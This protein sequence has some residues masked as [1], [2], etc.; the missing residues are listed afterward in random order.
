MIARLWRGRTVAQRKLLMS[1]VFNGA[2]R[3][4]SL[5]V[6]LI[7]LPI[8]LAGLG[9]D[10]YSGL[11][12]ALAIGASAAFLFGG[13]ASVG[14]RAIGEAASRG[15]HRGEADHFATLL[16][17]TGGTFLLLSALIICYAWWSGQHLALLLVML[18]PIAMSALNASVDSVRVPYNEQYV[19]AAILIGA[20]VLIYGTALLFLPFVARNELTAGLILNGPLIL[21]SLVNA[22]LMLRQRPYLAKGRS[23][24]VIGPAK[25]GG[26]VGLADGALMAPISLAVVW[27]DA[28]GP[29]NLSAWFATVVRLFQMLLTPMLLMLV[30]IAGYVR[31]IWVHSDPAKRR[32]LARASVLAGFG[33]G[34]LSATVLALLISFYVHRVMGLPPP[35]PLVALLPMLA[36]FAAVTTQK[37]YAFVAN[38]VLDAQHL[39]RWTL[40][41]MMVSMAIALAFSGWLSSFAV[42][43]AFCAC[44]ALPLLVIV[45]WNSGKVGSGEAG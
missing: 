13:Y 16:R 8:F 34:L 44:C 4:P 12:A 29:A 9:A 7:F 42:I 37:A 10:R 6:P 24:D 32:N 31:S 43:T 41:T 26:M 38:L 19:T 15:D 30:P 5:L 28:V 18:M 14:I 21:A 23:L 11:M 1:L 36:M 45:A 22:V 3:V 39:A 27:L 17:M 20:Q 25:R 35:G 33:Y 2:T 40:L